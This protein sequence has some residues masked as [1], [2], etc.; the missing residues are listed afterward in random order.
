[1]TLWHSAR[2]ACFLWC[3]FL[4]G[5]PPFIPAASGEV[6]TLRPPQAPPTP[7]LQPNRNHGEE[8]V[9]K[10]RALFRKRALVQFDQAAIAAAVGSGTLRSAKL[11]L[12][13][14]ESHHWGPE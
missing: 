10:I 8:S 6:Q 11:R 2:R 3:L 14:L 5:L 13:I 1:M 12:T 4:F 9:L 7:R